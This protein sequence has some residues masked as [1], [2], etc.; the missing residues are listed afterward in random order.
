MSSISLSRVSW[1]TPAGHPIF[2]EIELNFGLRRTGLVGR[3]GVG[4]ST[5]LR[6]MAGDL[7][8]SSGACS[9]TGTVHLMHQVVQPAASDRIADLFGVRAALDV[10]ARAAGGEAT[11]DDLEKADWTI[12]ERIDAALARVGLDASAATL[13]AGL[14][15]GQR[16]RAAL[17]AAIFAEPDFLLLD[18]PT[19]NLDRAG[20]DAV[21]RLVDGW[22]AGLVVVSHDR[23]L[24]EHMDAIVELT[25]LGA[26]PYGG[27]WS[28]YRQSKALELQA[29]EQDLLDARKRQAEIARR[30]RIADER[31]QRRD[32][33]GAR[34][35]ARGDMPKILAGARRNAAEASGGGDQRLKAR[36]G[37]DA[38][39]D[40]AAAQAKIEV[41]QS[42]SIV[43][44]TTK[45]D[46]TR[47]RV[48]AAWPRWLCRRWPKTGGDGFE[49]AGVGAC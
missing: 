24:L 4:K 5:L 17:A 43:L 27:N 31:K 32:A 16:T 14:S 18:E 20:R 45:V 9:T 48:S 35:A 39:R 28:A 21:L 40:V 30:S 38:A 33:A 44:P 11:L 23:E 10:L 3:N 42:L 34:K 49:H 37:D 41:L 22:S 25:T 19:N 12:E 26:T 7:T 6:I 1:V 2:R 15:G 8:P 13:L 47:A 29:A 46:G 36:L